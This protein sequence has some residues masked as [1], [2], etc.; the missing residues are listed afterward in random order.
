MDLITVQQEG[1][2]E[3]AIS[4]RKHELRSD[5][6]LDDGGQDAGPSP[7]EL[8]VCAL[9]ACLGMAVARYCQTIECPAGN[10]ELYLTYQLA[11]RPKRIESIVVDMEL[12]EG[13]PPERLPAVQRVVN[14]CPVHGTLTH[15]P[16]IDLEIDL[17]GPIA[18]NKD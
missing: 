4:V 12:P 18:T 6:S 16:K 17:R 13:F 14:S 1:A 9:G 10:I 5:M 7:T 15:P 2:Q 11:D 3:F 8:L